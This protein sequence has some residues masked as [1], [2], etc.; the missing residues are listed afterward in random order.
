LAIT[1]ARSLTGWNWL[2]GYRRALGLYGFFYAIAHAAIYVWLDRAGNLSS[3]WS[4]IVQRRFL[5]V[6]ALA[7]ILMIP[8]AVTSTDAMIRIL[9]ASRWKLLHRLAYAI[10]ALGILHFYMLV[11]SD[12]R[13][14]MIFGGIF[15]G[16]M[17]YRIAKA[18]IDQPKRLEAKNRKPKF[19]RGILVVSDIR[20]ETH[21]VKTLCLTSELGGR[22][23]FEFLA[24]QYLNVRLE[25][26]GQW[27]N[28]SY[29]IASS[30]SIKDHVEITVKRDPHG[31]VSR[32]L[33]DHVDVGTRIEVRAPSGKFVLESA[34]AQ[35]LVLIAGGVGITPIM[36]ILRD[37]NQKK[38]GGSVEL[39]Y[40]I[41]SH[42]DFVFGKEIVTILEQMPHLKL[43]LFVSQGNATLEQLGLLDLRSQVSLKSGR[44]QAADLKAIER[45]LNSARIFLCGPSNMMESVQ[46]L[47]V[48]CGVERSRITTEAFLSPKKTSTDAV[49]V[50]TGTAI[51]SQIHFVR[52]QRRTD[53]AAEGTILEASEDA[54]V[55]IGNE[56]R[57]GICGQCKVKCL[58]GSVTMDNQDAL[59]KQEAS[60]GWILACQAHATSQEVWID[61]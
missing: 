8:L 52:S 59:S 38:W 20:Q 3:A 40:C 23:P 37:L 39:L 25:I 48:H 30:P 32:F 6:G 5:T 31:N 19:W 28:R 9:G 49:V 13:E 46:D 33:H 42:E 7:V 24:G 21:N 36:S 60:A 44:L 16:L 14:P 11:K 47:I 55:E 57:S 56:C 18:C 51:D 61:A 53:I 29:T 12:V 2:I 15:V 34:N 22:L 27:V 17:G 50:G 35:S 43:Q 41:K 54:R 45:T 4:E 26:E 1:P 58:R 10:V